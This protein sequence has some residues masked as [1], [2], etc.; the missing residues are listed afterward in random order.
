MSLESEDSLTPTLETIADRFRLLGDATRLRILLELKS[1]PLSVNEIVDASGAQQANVSR[2]LN[3]LRQSGIVKR[4]KQ[5]NK[6][7]Y[8]INDPSVFEL[9]SCVCRGK[10]SIPSTLLD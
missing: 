5:G 9:C 8:S 7:I 3:Q 1:G 2:H 6:A 10:P 4:Q